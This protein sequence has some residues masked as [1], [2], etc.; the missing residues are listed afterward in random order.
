MKKIGVVGGGVIG[1]T[2]AYFLSLEGYEV[3]IFE[4]DGLGEEA[5]MKNAGLIVPGMYSPFPLSADLPTITKWLIHPTSPVKISLDKPGFNWIRYLIK[6]RRNPNTRKYVSIMRREGRETL[7]L[8]DEIIEKFN[9]DCS[10]R[11]GEI[12]EIYSD[13]RLFR[14]AKHY[15]NDILEDEINISVLTGDELREL[16]PCISDVIIGGLKYEEDGSVDPVCYIKGLLSLVKERDINIIN[17]NVNWIEEEDEVAIYFN[18]EEEKFSKAVIAT[19]PWTPDILRKMGYHMLIEAARGYVVTLKGCQHKL[20]HPLMVEETKIVVHPFSDKVV[21][22]GIQDFKGYDRSI[23]EKRINN[24]VKKTIDQAPCL[25]DCEKVD[26]KVAF[27]PCTPDE[28]PAV[29][30]MKPFKNIYIATGHCRFGLTYSVFTARLITEIINKE[31]L[32]D[33]FGFL[34]PS[35]LLI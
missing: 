30:R 11:R 22:A 23:P 14:E 27:R 13:P 25:T 5:S 10:Y 32:P 28:I 33:R 18:D 3:T 6:S 19:G 9:M 8:F 26:V 2:T 17:K 24:L 34:D 1:I 12:L 7:K 4:K 31:D 29:G 16:E 35:R 20:S 15:A 21:L